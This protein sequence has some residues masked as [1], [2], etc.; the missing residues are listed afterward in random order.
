M[1][2]IPLQWSRNLY[3]PRMLSTTL[4][5]VKID[6]DLILVH[7]VCSFDVLFNQ[8]F[9]TYFYHKTVLC[10]N[11]CSN[12]SNMPRR[13]LHNGAPSLSPWLSASRNAR[14]N[15]RNLGIGKD[16]SNGVAPAFVTMFRPT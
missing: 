15:L 9:P 8:C 13:N 5:S 1:A 12:P 11:H 4:H 2:K 7:F 6:K 14:N 16:S 3:V 10:N